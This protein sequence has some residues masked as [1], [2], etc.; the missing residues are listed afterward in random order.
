MTAFSPAD[1]G[2]SPLPGHRFRLFAVW[3]CVP[4]VAAGVLAPLIVRLDP[5]LMA[6]GVLLV[7]LPVLAVCGICWLMGV[8]ALLVR[9]PRATARDARLAILPVLLGLLTVGYVRFAPYP[10]G[11]R[12]PQTIAGYAYE[13]DPDAWDAAAA[14][15]R[16]TMER[17]GYDVDWHRKIAGRRVDRLGHD[18]H[19]GVWF[20][21]A[22][23][24]DFVDVTSYGLYHQPPGGSLV[25]GDVNGD[26]YPTSPFGA[27][28]F[29]V[30]PIGNGW[31]TFTAN[32]DYH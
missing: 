17:G 21:T 29:D 9:M 8:V 11:V 19:G 12:S 25:L 20:R 22:E 15:V 30:K 16:A 2:P 7:G 27:N 14:E 28:D 13:R 32:D 31:H 5:M 26:G 23:A 18:E 1:D 4:F 6:I 3:L 10:L 24:P